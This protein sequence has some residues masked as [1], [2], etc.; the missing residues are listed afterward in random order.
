MLDNVHFNNMDIK[1]KV[2]VNNNMYKNSI[3]PPKST[4]PPTPPPV[5]GIQDHTDN[6][7]NEPL[8]QYNHNN[9]SRSTSPGPQLM[10]RD[11]NHSHKNN[12]KNNEKKV[13]P[14]SDGLI[15]LQSLNNKSSEHE[16]FRMTL[17][18]TLEELIQ[19]FVKRNKSYQKSEGKNGLA[20]K[21]VNI[22]KEE[23]KHISL[24]KTDNISPIGDNNNNKDKTND[25]LALPLSTKEPTPD[26]VFSAKSTSV[27][28]QIS[29]ETAEKLSKKRDSGRENVLKLIVSAK[30]N[31]QTFAHVAHANNE[32]NLICW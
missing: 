20:R 31:S 16:I 18:L 17:K 13:P 24:H 22:L 4:T 32:Y 7:Q 25:N 19:E 11:S 27:E 9:K 10:H 6:R 8:F 29:M 14:L 23:V 5:I 15:A 26:S 3:S 21:L 28:S 1:H 2:A 12:D 30:T